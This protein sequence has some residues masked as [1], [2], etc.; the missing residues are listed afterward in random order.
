MVY[1]TSMWVFTIYSQDYII[2][3]WVF[4]IYS[5]DYITIITIYDEDPHVYYVNHDYIW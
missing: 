3:M 5:Q 1:I 4:T 2:N